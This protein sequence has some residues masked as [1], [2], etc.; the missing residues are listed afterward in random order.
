MAQRLLADLLVH[1]AA[2]LCTMVGPAGGGAA[3]A[4]VLRDG[5]VAVRG[6]R[7]I[8][9]GPSA[10]VADHVETLSDAEILDAA[11][12]VVTPG[13]VDPHTHLLF[14]GD[15]C[16]ELAQRLAGASYL[17]VARAGG[18]IQATV[19]ATRAMPREELVALAVARA[20]R[21]LEQGV[22]T[23]EVK[24][25]YGLSV[26]AELELLRAIQELVGRTPL[27]I[28]P[29]LLAL[30]ALPAEAREDR[31]GYVAEIASALVPRAATEGLC[32]MVDAFLEEGAFTAAEVEV[33]FE[34][35]RR[36]GLA[37]RLHADQLSPGG[38]A[39]LAASFGA[40]S[41]DHLEQVTAAGIEALAKA[42]TV[43]VLA[44]V[45]TWFLRLPA[46]AP[47]R[48]LLDAG[49]TIALC[50][51]WN[52]GSAPT[53]SVAL[54]LAAACLAYGLQP[55]EALHAFT[56]GAARA[57]GFGERLGRIAVGLQAD[58][59]LFGCSDHRHLV[60][61]LAIDHTRAVV[62]N[63]KLVARPYG[64]VCT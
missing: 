9:T 63:G 6:G 48:R 15:R 62:K 50:T 5:A 32:G 20:T 58:L 1:N 16:G 14:A 42:G 24:S 60:S 35:A 11:G 25:G 23:C 28:V 13:L 22:T 33:V 37:R 44:P 46:Y 21:L 52:P 43:A 55:G 29:T 57:L 8:W 36:H 34:A 53:E 47:A 61:H 2:E 54:T 4:G 45:A 30:H 39:Q 59:A 38:G 40:L 51:N 19:Q 64:A 18:G 56:A 26:S 41:A 27:E 31:A 3:A 17:D 7:I 49:V 12:H 10:E